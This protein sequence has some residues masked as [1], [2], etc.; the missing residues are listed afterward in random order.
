MMGKFIKEGDKFVY[1]RR[2]DWS[3]K[4][5]ELVGGPILER[6]LAA[7]ERRD[8][9]AL[10]PDE[11]KLLARQ[12]RMYQSFVLPGKIQVGGKKD[13]SRM[14]EELVEGFG[15]SGLSVLDIGCNTGYFAI[16]AKRQGAG[17]AVGVDHV[18]PALRIGRIFARV[19]GQEVQLRRCFFEEVPEDDRFDVVFANQILYHLPNP[20][21]DLDKI[22]RLCTRRF[23][24]YAKMVSH[25]TGIRDEI[26]I[27]TPD[28]FF[29]DFRTRGF[30]D[31]QMKPFRDRVSWG[32]TP[33]WPDSQG[34]PD[35]P[36]VRKFLVRAR[37]KS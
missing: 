26:Y 34:S 37:K 29:E 32:N 5:V 22:G 19:L 8:L 2:R 31:I 25:P 7:W 9:T 20:Q 23:L 16:E 36:K 4:L 6:R 24:G 35:S 27:P 18:E 10:T 15:L 11:L 17:R 33:S 13:S 14:F 1:R 21:R 3:H 28:E 12:F 30:V